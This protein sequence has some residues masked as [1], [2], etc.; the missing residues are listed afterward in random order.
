VVVFQPCETEIPFF[1]MP[2]CQ[3][4]ILPARDAS[5]EYS[6]VRKV[7]E[8]SHIATHSQIAYSISKYRNPW[9]RITLIICS[10]IYM[11]C[12]TSSSSSTGIPEII[13]PDSVFLCC[14]VHSRSPIRG[15]IFPWL[16]KELLQLRINCM[17][18]HFLIGENTTI[19]SQ[20][21]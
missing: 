2:R 8:S 17:W 5:T 18:L 3:Y 7:T 12:P 1:E 11:I 4:Q 19:H 10:R 13:S 9:S 14:G 6:F 21:L 15:C 20:S 16:D